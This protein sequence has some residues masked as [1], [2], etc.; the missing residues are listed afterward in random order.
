[1][2]APIQSKTVVLFAQVRSSYPE[3]GAPKIGFYSGQDTSERVWGS[4]LR[5][6]GL[7]IS[8]FSPRRSLTMQ[9]IRELLKG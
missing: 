8:V 9:A 2:F 7:S 3:C 1:M 4:V 5:T 6:E